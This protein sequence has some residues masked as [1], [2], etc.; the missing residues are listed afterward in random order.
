MIYY[1]ADDGRFH[2]VNNTS[3]DTLKHWKYIKKIP[4]GKS[5]R[6]FYSLDEWRAYLGQSVKETGQNIKKQISNNINFG[7][8]LYKYN[9]S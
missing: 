1:R 4:R 6:Y 9:F 7:N 8:S 5:F 3:K 2:A